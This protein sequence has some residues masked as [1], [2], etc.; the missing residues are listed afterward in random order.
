LNHDDQI[1]P[2]LKRLKNDFGEIIY[3]EGPSG[4]KKPV[5]ARRT[6]SR[7]T[8]AK[9]QLWAFLATMIPG[10]AFFGD[11]YTHAIDVLSI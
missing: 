4:L 7:I 9:K 1:E 10:E 11:K 5:V 3:V 6:P 2:C 8:I